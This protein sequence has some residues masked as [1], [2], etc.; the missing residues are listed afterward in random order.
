MLFLFYFFSGEG[1]SRSVTII[2]AY[3]IQIEKF[4]LLTAI[5]YVKQRRTIANPNNGFVKQL[6]EFEQKNSSN[7]KTTLEKYLSQC[8]DDW[9]RKKE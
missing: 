2:L 8:G 5:I 9:V 7:G 6:I 4:E 3:L 1:K